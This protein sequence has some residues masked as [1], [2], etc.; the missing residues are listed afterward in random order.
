[1]K[2]VLL[3]ALPIL[4]LFAC[5]KQE[6][7]TSCQDCSLTIANGET[8]P[9]KVTFSN[10]GTGAPAA[11]TLQVGETRTFTLPADKSITIAGDLQSPFAH[12]DFTGTFQCNGNCT[13]IGVVL[14]E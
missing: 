2:K 10:W 12:N 13:P 3:L 5:K 11:F 8:Y 1:M 6:E 14:K 7:S 4:I 9:Y